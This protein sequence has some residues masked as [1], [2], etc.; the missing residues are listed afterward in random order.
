MLVIVDRPRI[1]PFCSNAITGDSLVVSMSL[2]IDSNNFSERWK[3]SYSTIVFHFISWSGRTW[4]LVQFTT[5]S[6]LREIF[7]KKVNH[8]DSAHSD[9]YNSILFCV[10]L[11]CLKSCDKCTGFFSVSVSVLCDTAALQYSTWQ[12]TRERCTK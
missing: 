6:I 10:V 1:N 8:S 4:I 2:T 5:S 12:S 11:F 7:Q 9:I 3:N